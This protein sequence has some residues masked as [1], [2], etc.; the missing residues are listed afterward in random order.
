MTICGAGLV[1]ASLDEARKRIQES[2]DYTSHL[3][4]YELQA[5]VQR[6]DQVTE[7]DY[8][9]NASFHVRAW[10]RDEVDYMTSVADRT[11]KRLQKL[12][13]DLD[14]PEEIWLIKTTGAEEG[15]ANGYTRKNNIFLNQASLSSNLFRHELFH[16]ATRFD[17]RLRDD[18]YATIGF[19]PVGEIHYADPNRV[20]NPDAPTLQHALSV[21][22]RHQLRRVAIVLTGNRPYTGGSFFTYV[23]KRL[24]SVDDTAAE[25]LDFSQVSDLYEAIGRN[26]SYNIHQ[27]E[28]CASHFELLL[29]GSRTLPHPHLISDLRIVLSAKRKAA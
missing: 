19:K 25:L 27:E 26:T 28:V 17:S 7:T 4:P 23:S 9:V 1:F 20:S 8:L 15:G 12:K 2:D 10:T 6:L 22:Y 13:I 24:L 3:S 14:L 5:K 11:N 21:S 18:C 29:S 16:V